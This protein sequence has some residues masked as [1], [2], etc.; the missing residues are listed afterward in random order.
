MDGWEGLALHLQLE[1]MQHA[2]DRNTKRNDVRDIEAEARRR[3]QELQLDKDLSEEQRQLSENLVKEQQLWQDE[4]FPKRLEREG[5]NSDQSSGSNFENHAYDLFFAESRDDRGYVGI[6]CVIKDADGEV[7]FDSRQCIGVEIS[8]H[9]AEYTALING[10]AFARSMG[11]RRINAFG[12][13][14]FMFWEVTKASPSLCFELDSFLFN[15]VI[16][17]QIQT[18]II[19]IYLLSIPQY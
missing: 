1:E 16:L 15:S 3:K 5:S 7:V 18:Y 10:L 9:F 19:I 4:D 13:R 2:I 11:V 14:A 17:D 12:N 8:H 6:G